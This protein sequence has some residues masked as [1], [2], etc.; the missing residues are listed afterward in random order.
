MRV[1]SNQRWIIWIIK[2][3]LAAAIVAT[4]RWTYAAALARDESRGMHV[5]EDAPGEKRGYARSL[6]VG[7]L[8]SISTKFEADRVLEAAQ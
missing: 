5:R 6:R 8:G 4:S 2:L 1:R 7:G 3:F